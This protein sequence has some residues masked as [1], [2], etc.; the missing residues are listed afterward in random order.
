MKCVLSAL[1]GYVLFCVEVGAAMAQQ[2]AMQREL[3]LFREVP[4]VITAARREQPLTQAPSAI[5]VITAEEIRQS[6]ATSIP[7]CSAPS[8]AW[9]ELSGIL[10]V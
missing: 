3:L 6:G 8:P 5:T 4:T 1:V 7:E 9:R 10:H 2:P